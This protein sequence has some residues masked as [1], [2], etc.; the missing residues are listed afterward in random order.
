MPRKTASQKLADAFAKASRKIEEQAAR[1]AAQEAA[2]EAARRAAALEAFKNQTPAVVPRAE[3]AGPPG[4]RVR[5]PRQTKADKRAAQMEALR[6]AVESNRPVLPIAQPAPRQP[7]APRQPPGRSRFPPS[8]TEPLLKLTLEYSEGARGY[9]AALTVKDE[10]TKQ[11]YRLGKQDMPK[12]YPVYANRPIRTQDADRVVSE[13]NKLF[14]QD[15]TEII[16]AELRPIT[17]A[18][19]VTLPLYGRQSITL[20]FG[21]FEMEATSAEDCVPLAIEATMKRKT[22][23]DLLAKLKMKDRNEGATA[24]QL[25]DFC[26]AHDIALNLCDVGYN[27]IH[28]SEGA[29][30]VLHGLVKTENTHG[31]LYH[32]TNKRLIDAI[33]KPATAS[34]IKASHTPQCTR[35][36]ITFAS[37]IEQTEHMLATHE[38]R[39]IVK[40]DNIINELSTYIRT[41]NRVPTLNH[42]STQ[43]YDRNTRYVQR[44]TSWAYNGVS[45]A[46]V[47]QYANGILRSVC[48]DYLS[49]CN[50]QVTDIFKQNTTAYVEQFKTGPAYEYDIK[51]CYTAIIATVALPVFAFDDQP[52]PFCGSFAHTG[53][54]GIQRPDGLHYI[55]APLVRLYLELKSITTADI[56]TELIPQKTCSLRPFVNAVYTTAISADDKKTAI[57][58]A[59][60]CLSH[61]ERIT[62]QR[63]FITTSA[64]DYVHHRSFT[65]ARNIPHEIHHLGGELMLHSQSTKTPD[66]I[67]ARPAWHY[68]MQMGRYTLEKAAAHIKKNGGE[69][70]EIS[71]D[72]IYTTA[73]VDLPR[74]FPPIKLTNQLAGNSATVEIKDVGQWKPAAQ[75]VRKPRIFE[76]A[77]CPIQAAPP[78]LVP[79]T[80]CDTLPKTGCLILGAPGTGKTTL[81][82]AYKANIPAAQI[83]EL[84]F[85]NNVVANLNSKTASTFHKKLRLK[86]NEKRADVFLAKRFEGIKYIFIDEIQMTPA[87]VRPFLIWLKQTLN[88]VFYC[89]GDFKQWGCIHDK[90]DQEAAWLKEITGNNLLTLTVN[91]RNPQ[92][93]NIHKWRL[94]EAPALGSPGTTKYH[95]AYRNVTVDFINDAMY[96][97][98]LSTMEATGSGLV[99][100]KSGDAPAVPMMCTRGNKKAGFIKG[101]HYLLTDRIITLD[102]AFHT[103]E[104]KADYQPEYGACFTLG[105]A[106]TCHK[107]IGLTIRQPYTIHDIVTKNPET[108]QT[109]DYVARSRAV[110]QSQIYLMDGIE[111]V[112]MH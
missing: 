63:S 58:N 14:P 32:L 27:I 45:Y 101:R 6:E 104:F 83:A 50:A 10:K 103:D 22:P 91:H 75:V 49:T 102:P 61:Q 17:G 77:K 74:M 110:D 13:L 70:R 24:R 26:A 4:R 112:A 1:E 8:E 84:S 72:A 2:Q 81:W 87:T 111:R 5:L 29:A 85:Q 62:A 11:P 15:Y 66:N 57:N 39:A 34:N 59:I 23:A 33:F 52:R 105:Y 108:Q 54:Y 46:S 88:I 47:T 51:K 79:Y 69:V 53:F 36:K 109:Y 65:T 21:G 100:G 18:P 37:Q 60:G 40:V 107:T 30:F 64:T 82:G 28:Q 42:S 92:M 71:T 97:E 25:I 41:N 48:P 3:P 16:S 68:I 9:D 89:A 43:F 90:F 94:A 98:C 86:M 44:V 93:H 12:L 76:Q 95:I 73:P 96:A 31:H 19:I 99:A 78:A 7:R 67:N 56:K 35:C 20:T 106:F 38:T 55:I 80:P